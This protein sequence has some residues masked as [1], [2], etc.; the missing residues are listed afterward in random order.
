[1]SYVTGIFNVF[2]MPPMM[3]FPTK[4]EEIPDLEPSIG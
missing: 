1:M 2:D 3:S 4:T